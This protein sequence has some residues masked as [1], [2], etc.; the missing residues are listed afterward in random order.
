M[1][2]ISDNKDKKV[3]EID[4]AEIAQSIQEE[5]KENNQSLSS[6]A[7]QLKIAPSKRAVLQMPKEILLKHNAL[8]FH[9]GSSLSSSQRKMVQDRVVYGINR[10][11]IKPE[12]VAKEINMLNAHIQG[13]LVKIIDE[14]TDSSI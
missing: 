8:I 12:E 11:W 6:F 7:R 4:A 13:E 9:K 2:D 1:T 5:L 10:G 3:N 14:N